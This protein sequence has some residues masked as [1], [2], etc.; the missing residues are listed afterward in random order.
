MGPLFE[1]MAVGPVA[2]AYLCAAEQT[3]DV[4]PRNELLRRAKRA[5]NRL[6]RIG[7]R[8]S[9]ESV[10]EALRL[11]GTYSWLS[12]DKKHAVSLW[13]RG[14]KVAEEMQAIHVLAKLHHEMGLRMTTKFMF[15]WRRCYSSPPARWVHDLVGRGH[16]RKEPGLAHCASTVAAAMPASV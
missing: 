16:K 11:Q 13:Q 3:P 5:C 15:N 10:P 8:F 4:R 9:D 12:D 2:E 6:T 1:A 14:I 7:R